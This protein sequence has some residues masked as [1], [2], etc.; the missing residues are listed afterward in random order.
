MLW[1]GVLGAKGKG[2]FFRTRPFHLSE[3]NH[4]LGGLSFISLDQI[5]FDFL[6]FLQRSI[7]SPRD[8]GVVNE[9][10]SSFGVGC[11]ETITL[12]FVEPLH[13]PGGMH[14]PAPS[15]QG[16]SVGGTAAPSLQVRPI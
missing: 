10:I 6:A 13:G 14:G 5:E 1:G 2:G 12:A 16:I 8:P 11:N 9:T 3:P 15:I 7:S 4:I